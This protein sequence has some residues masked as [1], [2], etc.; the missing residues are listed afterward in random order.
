MYVSGI[1]S[2]DRDNNVS[3]TL[4]VELNDMEKKLESRNSRYIDSD[5]KETD[6]K[7]NGWEIPSLIPADYVR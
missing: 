4:I 1:S 7:E 5:A 6:M 3:L 2:R